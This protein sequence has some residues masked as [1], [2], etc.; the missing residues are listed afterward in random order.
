MRETWQHHFFGKAGV[1]ATGIRYAADNMMIWRPEANQISDKVW[2]PSLF[3]P[4]WAARILLEI[5]DVR[6]ERLNDISEEDA[7]AEGIYLT[8]TNMFGGEEWED[9]L[10][11]NLFCPFAVDSYKS[12]WRKI[13]GLDSWDKNPWVWVVCFKVVQP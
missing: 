1:N 8:H 9:Y 11:D 4:R 2:R 7:K 5:T 12:L 10:D 13:N 3:M 6:V